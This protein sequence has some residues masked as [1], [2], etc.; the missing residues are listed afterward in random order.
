MTF[1]SVRDSD[2]AR[3]ALA[4]LCLAACRS[5][6]TATVHQ[7]ALV[8]GANT[9][10]R[11]SLP[12]TI[13][14][15]DMEL[16]RVLRLV[17]SAYYVVVSRDRLRFHLMLHNKW[18]DWCDV[19]NWG[20]WLEDGG[21]NVYAPERVDQHVRALPSGRKPVYRGTASITFYE[22]DIF[23]HAAK[24]T[25]VLK[26]PGYEYRYVW[27]SGPDA[28]GLAKLTPVSANRVASTQ[29]GNRPR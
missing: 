11:T 19:R 23:D 29:A 3:I 2:V 18:D 12:A 20:V 14:V 16:P 5:N 28:S 4:I 8:L 13:A 17:N 1:A 27:I 7:P 10:S 26:R 21:G 25:L 15:R 24:L 22:R 9:E 6:W